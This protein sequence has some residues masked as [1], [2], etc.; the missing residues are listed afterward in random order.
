M[1][2]WFNKWI[3]RNQVISTLVWYVMSHWHA[4]V[5]IRI[6]DI[7]VVLRFYLCSCG[8]SCLLLSWCVGDRCDMAGSD[9]D[10]G[11]SRGPSVEEW[12]LSGTGQVL[13]GWTM[14]RSGDAVCGLHRVHKDEECGFLAWAWKPR[15]TISQFGPQNSQLWFCDLGLKITMTVSW[16]GPQNHAGFSLSVAP[17]NRRREVGTGHASRSSGFLRCEASLVVFLSRWI[18]GSSFF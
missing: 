5:L 2:W 8:K 15:S 17:Q 18:K 10:C 7:S 14:V 4:E 16:F 13:G 6:W 1:H 11:R 3:M 9:E 12:G